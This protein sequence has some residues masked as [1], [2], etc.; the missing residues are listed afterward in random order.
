MRT[1]TERLIW[2]AENSAAIRKGGERSADP[3]YFM[4]YRNGTTS[5]ADNDFRAAIDYGIDE[6]EAKGKLVT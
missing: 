2:I 1:D 6:A 3:Y 5:A 4:I